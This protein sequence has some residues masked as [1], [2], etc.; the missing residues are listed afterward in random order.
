LLKLA[1]DNT[2]GAARLQLD[3]QGALAVDYSLETWVVTSLFTDVEATPE[4]I[5]A[6]GL[7]A[8]RGW[9]AEADS[10][11]DP[12]RPRMGSKLWLL[13]RGKTT[14]ETLRRAEVY[15]LEALRWMIA[16]GVAGSIEVLASRP[17]AGML[18]LEVTITR[19]KNLQPAFRRFW[20][21]QSNAV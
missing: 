19:P 16:A 14:V 7:A 12:D 2:I 10:L 5:T 4:E 18:G 11:R 9:W 3:Q 15:A 8:Q 1:W 21:F 20:E 17:R 6:A 13:S